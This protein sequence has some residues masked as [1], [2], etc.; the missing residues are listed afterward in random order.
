MKECGRPLCRTIEQIVF[1][2][3][4]FFESFD[5][6]RIQIFYLFFDNFL[7][8]CCYIT[9]QLLARWT[10]RYVIKWSVARSLFKIV[11]TGVAEKSDPLK[12]SVKG[13]AVEIFFF[14]FNIQPLILSSQISLFP[15]V[16]WLL[17]SINARLFGDWRFNTSLT[18]L[19][20]HR[21]DLRSRWIKPNWIRSS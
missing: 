4:T 16:L 14:F 3:Y 19:N 18:S 6:H 10:I 21:I 15:F 1:S 20:L 12:E 8:C 13:E 9:A 7:F 11:L 5:N 2:F 17:K